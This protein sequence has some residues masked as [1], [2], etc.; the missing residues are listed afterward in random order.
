VDRYTRAKADAGVVDF[1]DLLLKARD[2]IR[3]HREART[4]FQRRFARIS[5]DEFQDTD[6]LQAE[7]LLLLASDDP[8]IVEWRRVRPVPGKLFLVGDP[9]PSIYRF[10]RADVGIYQYVYKQLEEAGAHRVT[11]GAS[12][13]ARPNIQRV[14]N[15]AF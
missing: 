13:R 15:A 1:L 11:L 5:V 9:K 12:F 8:D 14:I 6:P 4:S 3:D 7:I 10:R 2:L